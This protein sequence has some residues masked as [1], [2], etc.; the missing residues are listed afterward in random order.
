MLSLK[1]GIFHFSRLRLRALSART[2][3]HIIP[4]FWKLNSSYLTLIDKNHV[5][6]TALANNQMETSKQENLQIYKF[7]IINLIVK[8]TF[9]LQRRKFLQ[10]QQKEELEEQLLHSSEAFD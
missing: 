3:Y 10:Q 5:A 1:I 7:Y 9:W 2:A 4:K 8:I 6:R